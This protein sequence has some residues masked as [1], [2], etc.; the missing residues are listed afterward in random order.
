MS[1]VDSA[2][3]FGL[4]LERPEWMDAILACA[5]FQVKEIFCNQD[6]RYD[7]TRHY[8]LGCRGESLDAFVVVMTQGAPLCAHAIEVMRQVEV[9]TVL[10]IGTC[11]SLQSSLEIGDCL[12][13]TSA[14]ASEGTSLALVPRRL[15]AGPDFE[16]V[17]AV[18]RELKGAGLQTRFGM[19]HSRDHI[20]TDVLGEFFTTE[21]LRRLHCQAI[22]M[23]TSAF[24]NMC[25]L[26]RRSCAALQVIS[27]VIGA[28]EPRLQPERYIERVYKRMPIL[29]KALFRA[30]AARGKA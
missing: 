6:A 11:G 27:D 10:R 16:L 12:L 17:H 25:H 5:D 30:A 15:Q 28:A 18:S 23:E 24:F 26:R 21:E 3:T 19:I 8:L 1:F 22:D 9:E 29:T 20:R 7:P 2:T 14:F 4:L 13:P